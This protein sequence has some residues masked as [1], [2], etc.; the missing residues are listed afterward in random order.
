MSV[1][2][3]TDSNIKQVPDQIIAY[4]DFEAICVNIKQNLSIFISKL[5]NKL[6]DAI[7]HKIPIQ[8]LLYIH[9]SKLT[10]ALRNIFA[11]NGIQTIEI[12]SETPYSVIKT[13][14][15][16]I[17]FLIY[18]L[19]TNNESRA[20]TLISN[21]PDCHHLLSKIYST[22][23]ITNLYFVSL[24]IIINTQKRYKILQ[25]VDEIIFINLNNI[26][27]HLQQLTIDNTITY[28]HL[29][30]TTTIKTIR[31]QIYR[32]PNNRK[33]FSNILQF[34][35]GI[36]L[37]Y[38]QTE[39]FNNYSIW[40]YQIPDGSTILWCIDAERVIKHDLLPIQHNDNTKMLQLK[41]CNLRLGM[42][43]STQ[44][45]PKNKKLK[46]L[47]RMIKKHENII[48]PQCIRLT[49]N[50][51]LLTGNTLFARN[52]C[53]GDMLEWDFRYKI[54]PIQIALRNKVLNTCCK[55]II[56]KKCHVNGLRR[57]AYKIDNHYKKYAKVSNYALNYNGNKLFNGT[58]FHGYNVS[59]GDS[60]FWAVDM[61][62][63]Q[64]MLVKPTFKRQRNEFIDI[65]LQQMN[66]EIMFTMVIGR[67]SK[68][69]KL[70]REVYEKNKDLME[71]EISLYYN[72][73]L[74]S[75]DDK[76]EDW[77]IIDGATIFWNI[78]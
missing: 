37:Y 45:C 28:K 40:D 71:S 5:K 24:Q 32:S 75:V 50:G 31:Q 62:Q 52:I 16:D 78:E 35:N 4:C 66:T 63:T 38:K 51:K 30:L 26:T 3:S 46:I 21:D 65:T 58:V 22:P 20:L 10:S 36:S 27:L 25:Y 15:I 64:A 14:M 11:I 67:K 73:L 42:C 72:G 2:L 47:K 53:N 60:I 8:I 59:N 1:R 49:H 70:W 48:I 76:I 57:F 77:Y 41:I 68:I 56:G 39:L 13:L 19:N 55:V 54:K 29:K 23:P 6:W 17:A 34:T 61:Q 18:E 7:K 69:C 43:F 33:L 44:I 12:Q 9:T 74:L